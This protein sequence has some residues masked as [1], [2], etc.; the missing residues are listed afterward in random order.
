MKKKKKM[1]Y[2]KICEEYMKKS[3]YI[4]PKSQLFLK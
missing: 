1:I 4:L 2:M 3:S